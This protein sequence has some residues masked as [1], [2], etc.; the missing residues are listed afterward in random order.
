MSTEPNVSY[1]NDL[2]LM[3]EK[4]SRHNKTGG[5]LG[6]FSLIFALVFIVKKQIGVQNYMCKMLFN[7][8]LNSSFKAFKIEHYWR[9]CK[10]LLELE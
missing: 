5:F 4:L 6:G 1:S 10:L 7:I 2:A 9:F 8:I 3:K